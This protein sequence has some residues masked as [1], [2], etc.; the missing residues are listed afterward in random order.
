M[1]LVMHTANEPIAGRPLVKAFMASRPMTRA[2]V[3]TTTAI[4]MINGGEVRAR[5][6][7]TFFLPHAIVGQKLNVLPSTAVAHV[8]HR[9][10]NGDSVKSVLEHDRATAA[11]ENVD[12]SLLAG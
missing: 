7:R 6:S 2:S 12:V 3:T 11:T 5:S 1:C 10:L 8:N 9:I 4:T